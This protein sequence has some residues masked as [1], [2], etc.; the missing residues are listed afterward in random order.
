MSKPE[1]FIL[2]PEMRVDGDISIPCPNCRRYFAA[3]AMGGHQK[4]CHPFE[5]TLHLIFSKIRQIQC[6]AGCGLIH[7]FDIS[8]HLTIGCAAAIA[9]RDPLLIDGVTY[10]QID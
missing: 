10:K 8:D 3:E 1:P 5:H 7:P 4:E 2:S 6:P 9:E